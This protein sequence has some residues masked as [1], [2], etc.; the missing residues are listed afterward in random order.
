MDKS[1]NFT[2]FYYTNLISDYDIW[3]IDEIND[4]SQKLANEACK[5]W[6]LPSKYQK[7]EIPE[8]PPTFNYIKFG[9]YPQTLNDQ[10]AP[11]EWQVLSIENNKMLVI[12]RYGLDSKRF[13]S[14]SNN[15]A[16]SEIRQ[17]LNGEFYNK[18]FTEQEKMRIN[19]SNLSDVGTSD[20]VFLLSKEEAK[21]YFANNNERKCKATE[22]AKK[23]GVY[24]NSANDYGIWWLRSPHSD[25]SNRVYNI[26][27]I[28]SVGRYCGVHYSDCAV[29]PALWI[30]L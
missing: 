22:Y 2:K 7:K 8:L 30:N 10:N 23:N 13:D 3:Q 14:S 16:N 21:K 27:S 15:W 9:N 6:K 26:I 19:L 20:N 29:R 5:I 4:R 12:S 18:A 28:G 1:L 25:Y 24:V 11:I 17:W